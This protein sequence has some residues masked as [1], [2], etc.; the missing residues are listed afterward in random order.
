[1]TFRQLALDGG[2]TFER[3]P[4]VNKFNQDGGVIV[5]HQADEIV[6]RGVATTKTPYQWRISFTAQADSTCSCGAS[7]ATHNNGVANYTKLC[8]HQIAGIIAADSG[9]PVYTKPEVNRA[10]RQSKQGNGQPLTI[11]QAAAAT[12][13]A[14]NKSQSFKAKISRAISNAIDSLIEQVESVLARG[15]IPFLLGPTGCGKTSCIDAIVLKLGYAYETM[16]GTESYGDADIVGLH[17]SRGPIKGLIARAF[18]RAR[19]GEK[20]VIFIDEFLRF[21][22]RVQNLFMLAL[23]PRSAEIAKSLGIDTD[24]P[25]YITEAPVWGMEYAPVENIIWMFGAN[26]WGAQVDPAFAR[27]VQP[28]F[29]GYS[30]EAVKPLSLELGEFIKQTWALVD[31][32]TLPLPIEYGMIAG[33][34]NDHDFS[35]FPQYLDKL[36]MIDPGLQILVS[37]MVPANLNNSI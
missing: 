19:N 1:M 37:S 7:Y 27:R 11:A 35:I 8:T 31:A 6:L 9:Y 24:K 26:P 22:K 5:L 30:E 20:V 32:G 14:G 28:I 23:L 4:N 3:E 18:E 21:D 16:G 13:T 36:R 15:Q 34:R 33:M 12:T 29:V 17:T 2:F 25:V 10:P